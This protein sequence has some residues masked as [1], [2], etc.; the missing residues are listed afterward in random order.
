[1]L[2]QVALVNMSVFLL[3]IVDKDVADGGFERYSRIRHWKD[4]GAGD[5]KIFLGHLIAMGLVHKN[6]MEKY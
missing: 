3:F 4:I 5:I 1:M 6:N 2:S